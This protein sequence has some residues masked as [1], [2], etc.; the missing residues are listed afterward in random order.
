MGEENGW[1]EYKLMILDRFERQDE[2]F[3][4]QEHQLGAIFKTQSKILVEIAT[5][6]VKAGIWGALGAAVAGATFILANALASKLF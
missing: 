6:Q 4:R 3:D 5:L 2:R 1:D